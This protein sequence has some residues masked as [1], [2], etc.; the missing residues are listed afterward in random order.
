M[1]FHEAVLMGQI[2]LVQAKDTRQAQ[3]NDRVCISNDDR[4]AVQ[5]PSASVE[6]YIFRYISVS[7]WRSM[8]IHHQLSKDFLR[9]RN[10]KDNAD[11]VCN[12]LI[13]YHLETRVLTISNSLGLHRPVLQAH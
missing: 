11:L 7:P 6:S 13:I 12:I 1:G 2:H 3:R 9:S 5:S 8:S 4:T 10:M